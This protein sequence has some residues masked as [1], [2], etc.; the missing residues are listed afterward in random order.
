[1]SHRFALLF[2]SA[3]G[4]SIAAPAFAQDDGRYS[5]LAEETVQA[6]ETQEVPQAVVTYESVEVVQD[7]GPEAASERLAEEEQD[8]P[9]PMRR[10]AMHREEYREQQRDMRHELHR[11]RHHAAQ[12]YRSATGQTLGY[13]PED[14]EAW[15]ADCRVL[16]LGDDG[17]YGERDERDGDGNLIGGL[18]GAIVGG[19][20]GNRIAGRGDRLPGTILGAGIGGVAGLAIGSVIDAV[21]GGDDDD[22]Y[23]Y[24][25][26]E[27]ADAAQY[28]EAYLRRYES[29][30]GYAHAVYAQPVMMAPATQLVRR[31]G[32]YREVVREEWVDV[33]VAVTPRPAR[34]AAPRAAPQ[35]TKLTPVK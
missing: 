19:I 24:D 5:T 29:G 10:T 30:G 23:E 17:Y 6:L 12:T 21:S 33:P 11:E 28:C 35:S 22:R 15:L 4:L 27:Y 32:R 18:L 13:S 9:P 7:I 14:R 1:M 20:A 25:D 16:Y 31:P 26:R 3:A 2:A 34:R 8:M